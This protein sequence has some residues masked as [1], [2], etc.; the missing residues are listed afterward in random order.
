[1]ASPPSKRRVTRSSV[2]SDDNVLSLFKSFRQRN[3]TNEPLPALSKASVT[4]SLLQRY[5]QNYIQ[6]KKLV[7]PSKGINFKA[8]AKLQTQC[9]FLNFFFGKN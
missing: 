4:K 5:G 8:T 6:A 7:K 9:E 1:M 2:L 3:P